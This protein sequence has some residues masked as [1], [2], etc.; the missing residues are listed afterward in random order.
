M[1][2]RAGHRDVEQ[3]LRLFAVRVLPRDVDG[4][5]GGVRRAADARAEREVMR[6]A[7]EQPALRMIQRPAQVRQD[8]D[9][10]LQAFCAVNGVKPYDICRLLFRRRIAF[11]V[12]KALQIAQ[13]PD[14][15]PHAQHG[16]EFA[17]CSSLRTL[18]SLRRPLGRHRRR[19]SYEVREI[20]RSSR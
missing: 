20:S 10:E 4:A 1:L 8:H 14:E 16:S 18:A 19:A 3:A 9:R 12:G 7:D 15:L 17:I 6:V 11:A 13:P 5:I 2:P